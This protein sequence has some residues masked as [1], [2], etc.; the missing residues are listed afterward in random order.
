MLKA[1][2]QISSLMD[3]VERK[4]NDP[5]DNAIESIFVEEPVQTSKYSENEPI[6]CRHPFAGNNRV[7]G[8]TYKS[9]GK[10]IR[11]LEKPNVHGMRIGEEQ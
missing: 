3:E 5:F 7:C 10:F 8:R 9:L 4:L 11:H 1:T 6:I 2:E